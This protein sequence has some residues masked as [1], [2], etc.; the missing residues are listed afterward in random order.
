MK[1]VVDKRINTGK[2]S[3]KAVVEISREGAPPQA[4]ELVVKAQAGHPFE[5]QPSSIRKTVLQGKPVDSIT[6]YYD[7]ITPAESDLWNITSIRTNAN[8]QLIIP[9]IHDNSIQADFEVP[10]E[11]GVYE[12]AIVVQLERNTGQTA[13]VEI[14]VELEVHG[15]VI[16]DVQS[17]SFGAVKNGQIK[18]R[19][20]ELRSISRTP[21]TIDSYE[22]SLPVAV[23]LPKKSTK[24]DRQNVKIIVDGS[25]FTPNRLHKGDLRF[26]LNSNGQTQTCKVEVNLLRG[27]F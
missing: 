2:I 11:N 22:T 12:D 1:V 26:I 3:E 7:T 13:T 15:D 4:V 10:N 18:E 19:V 21:F 24:A 16:T 6:V 8:P 5:F 25:K 23:T 9:A 20:L 27:N 14:P 17:L